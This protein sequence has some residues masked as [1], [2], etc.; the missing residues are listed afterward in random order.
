[1]SSEMEDEVSFVVPHLT[2]PSGNHYRGSLY[3][4][5]EGRMRRKIS[6][7]AKAYRDAVAMFA[8]GRTVA[9]PDALKKKT[10][11]DVRITVVLG[12][13][14][15]GDEDNFHKVGLDALT[16]AGVIHSDAFAH[17]VCDVIR[18]DRSNPRTI[19][20]V[21]RKDSTKHA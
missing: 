12:P 11:Y 20:T 13:G 6:P 8:R 2:P 10:A 18:H 17:C 4:N 16:R 21:T 19:Y 3:W 7:D 5:H 1:M 15:R 9:P 14:Q